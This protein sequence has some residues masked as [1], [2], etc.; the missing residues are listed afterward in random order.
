MK[1]I[2]FIL[3]LFWACTSSVWATC[4]GGTEVTGKNGHVYCKSNV[5]MNWYSAFTWCEAQG[6]TLATMEQMCNIDETQKWDGSAGAG[7]CLNLVVENSPSNYWGWTAVPY[8]TTKAFNVN[9]LSGNV[10]IYDRANN[11]SVWCW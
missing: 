3:G 7:K 9:L 4:N 2:L 11:L 1:K 10:N 8:D 6:R 5:T